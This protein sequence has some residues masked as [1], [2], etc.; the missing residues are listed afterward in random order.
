MVLQGFLNV[1][2]P[3]TLLLVILGTAWGLTAGALP[4]LSASMAV[5]LMLPFTYGMEADSKCC[6][7]CFCLVGAMCGGSISAI[8]LK[9]PGTPSS[10][11]TTFDG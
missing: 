9:T 8:L 10:V 6:S 5:I 7:T 4:G 2:Q 1:L 11:A 3:M